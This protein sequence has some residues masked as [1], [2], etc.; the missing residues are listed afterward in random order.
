MGSERFYPEERSAREVS[1]EG[2]WIDRRPRGFA[3]EANDSG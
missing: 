3:G 1:V 2:F